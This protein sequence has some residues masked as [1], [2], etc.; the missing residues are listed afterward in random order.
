[1]SDNLTPLSEPIGIVREISEHALKRWVERTQTHSEVRAYNTLKKFLARSEE[2]QLAPQ[3]RA[4]ALLN[5]NLEPAR[6]LRCETWVFVVSMDGVLKT[7]HSG[8]AD[9]WLAPDQH[10][11]RK[12]SGARRS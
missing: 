5:H 3:Y 8:G 7:V 1:M 2:V 12:R 9:R 11:A 6:Y 10:S 4:K